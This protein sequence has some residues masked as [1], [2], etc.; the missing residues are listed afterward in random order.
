MHGAAY[1]YYMN[2]VFQSSSSLI[3]EMSNLFVIDDDGSK[4][5]DRPSLWRVVAAAAWGV[6]AGI[7]LCGIWQRSTRK[8]PR[9]VLSTEA[10]APAGHYSQAVVTSDGRV[11]VSGLLPITATGA[12]LTDAPFGDQARLVL[13]HM[14]AI[15]EASGSDLAHIVKCRIY[16]DDVS[17]WP[18]FN[19]IY[20]E[21]MGD[22]APA[23]V[24]VPVPVL[25]FDAKIEIECSAVQK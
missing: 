18:E 8:Q 12:K 7:A 20:A 3:G 1:Y 13:S 11:E 2:C 5:D 15:L 14:K 10:C 6:G 9:A 17:N 25:H 24:V 4:A 22:W 19:Q 16:V 21:A 23:R